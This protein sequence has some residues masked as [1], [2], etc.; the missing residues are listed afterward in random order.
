[1]T[2]RTE[3]RLLLVLVATAVAAGAV[4]ATYCFLHQRHQDEIDARLGR[5]AP[6]LWK[7]AQANSLPPELLRAVVR[8][9]SGGDERAVS[10][11]GAKGLM[12]IT[13]VALEE[14]RRLQP[15]GEGDLFDPDFNVRVGAAYL[16][17]LVNRFD[18][19]VY[20]AV[21]AYNMGPKRLLQERKAA[22]DSTG[23]QIVHRVAPPATVRYCRAIL[24]DREPRL[25]VTP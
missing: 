24:G 17:M 15:L 4:G 12:Q 1:M 6:I 21:A 20:L 18:G 9:E 16:R 3:K 13:P 2:R 22:P 14:V 8:A 11:R 7:H 25:P 23:R 19:D 10:A 5:L